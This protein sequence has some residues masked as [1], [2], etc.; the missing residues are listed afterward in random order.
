MEKIMYH[1]WRNEGV[2]RDEFRD[3]LISDL[4][5]SLS[6]LPNVHSSRAAV[7][8]DRI[9]KA[10]S[11]DMASTNPKPDAVVSIWVDSANDYFRANVDAAVEQVTSRFH[12]WVVSESQPYPNTTHPEEVGKRCEGMT[13]IVFLEKPDRMDYY[14]WLNTWRNSH[15]FVGIGTQSIY[16]YRQNLIGRPLTY[17]APGYVAFIEEDFPEESCFSDIHYYDEQNEKADW[18]QLV[19]AQFPEAAKIRKE[20]EAKGAPRWKINYRIMV[21]SCERFIDTGANPLFPQKIDCTPYSAYP[22]TK[23]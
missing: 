16:G 22:L 21:E 4:A 11:V 23:P 13:Q 8:D 18:D 9:A 17:G 10:T 15:S 6:A 5:A 20:M 7:Y 1:V 2:T 3:I 12:A 19:D 14:E